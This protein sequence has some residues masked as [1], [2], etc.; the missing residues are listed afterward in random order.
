MTAKQIMAMMMPKVLLVLLSFSAIFIVDG[1]II[2]APE[3]ASKLGG[4]F[5][6][7]ETLFNKYAS[8]GQ[9]RLASLI[10]KL[11]QA[12]YIYQKKHIK[13]VLLFDDVILELDEIRKRKLVNSF[14]EYDQTFT[15]DIFIPLFNEKDYLDIL[16]LNEKNENIIRQ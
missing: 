14:K 4:Y 10:I 16:D 2:G 6:M 3:I 12:E 15:E 9:C 1:F 8:F 7:N 5:Y 11:I 13:P